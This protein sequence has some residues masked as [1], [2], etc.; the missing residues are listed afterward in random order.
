MG[1]VLF[2]TKKG[3]GGGGKGGDGVQASWIGGE[4]EWMYLLRNGFF[5]Y[6]IYF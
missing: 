3:M 5:G 4:K 1:V 6:K 2:C